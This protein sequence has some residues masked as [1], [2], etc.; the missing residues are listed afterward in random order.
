MGWGMREKAVIMNAHWCIWITTTD[1]IVCGEGC[2]SHSKV[3]VT[4][5]A[6]LVD[7]AAM[8]QGCPLLT[9]V[10][11][12]C[13]PTNRLHTPPH[14]DISW[15]QD[16]PVHRLSIVLRRHVWKDMLLHLNEKTKGWWWWWWWW[17]WRRRWLGDEWWKEDHEENT[18][19]IA[20]SRTS[21]SLVYCA[22]GPTYFSDPILIWWF[23][24]IL[25][26]YIIQD[27]QAKAM[28]NWPITNM[29][30]KELDCHGEKHHTA[31]KWVR[32]LGCYSVW[33]VKMRIKEEIIITWRD[34]PCGR[35]VG[36][37]DRWFHFSDR[38]Y[39]N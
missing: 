3:S 20:S 2:I 22:V 8:R 12:V 1:W 14:L 24:S 25:Y 38:F 18:F 29:R 17:W 32:Y 11:N 30:N 39:G 5:Y 28:K 21:F 33:A 37:S 7:L 15:H 19:S 13:F 26:T 34:G 36:S 9:L 23:V 27:I 16:P 6:D 31:V 35:C 4:K 10:L